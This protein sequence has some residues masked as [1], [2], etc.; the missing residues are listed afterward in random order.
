MIQI[1]DVHTPILTRQ[2]T[3]CFTGSRIQSVIHL[4][5]REIINTLVKHYEFT[6]ERIT[7][8]MF[9][10]MYV[11]D[12]GQHL[13]KCIK[14]VNGNITNIKKTKIVSFDKYH[15]ARLYLRKLQFVN[16]QKKP[17]GNTHTHCNAWFQSSVT[18]LNIY[19]KINSLHRS[20]K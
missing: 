16:T 20:P 10:Y 12:I 14:R 13:I 9:C 2:F 8:L 15:V 18:R 11:R 4:F 1:C 17:Q 3:F 7:R 6:G 5:L 19:K